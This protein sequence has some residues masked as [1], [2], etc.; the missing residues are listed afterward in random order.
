MAAGLTGFLD[1]AAKK[2]APGLPAGEREVILHVKMHTH[3]H[4][5][6]DMRALSSKFRAALN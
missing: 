3:I 4:N 2:P 6:P 1:A 5:T